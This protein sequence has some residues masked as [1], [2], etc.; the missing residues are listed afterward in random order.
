MTK[1]RITN[2]PDVLPNPGDVT[3]NFNETTGM[4]NITNNL[5]PEIPFYTGTYP[6]T[7][8]TDTLIFTYE[9][10][11][12]IFRVTPYLGELIVFTDPTPNI[13][14]DGIIFHFVKE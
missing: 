8:T 3:W 2:S 7:M 14:D 1:Y 4:L 10:D 6:Y 13:F 11:S 5:E 9:G 12:K